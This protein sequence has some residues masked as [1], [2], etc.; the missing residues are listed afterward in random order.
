MYSVNIKKQLI[1][2]WSWKWIQVS[3]IEI[4]KKYL[5]ILLWTVGLQ[6]LTTACF[7]NVCHNLS[8]MELLFSLFAD[9]YTASYWQEGELVVACFASIAV[10]LRHWFGF[11]ILIWFWVTKDYLCTQSRLCDLEP[12]RANCC[13]VE[14]WFAHNF[15]SLMFFLWYNPADSVHAIIGCHHYSSRDW[16]TALTFDCK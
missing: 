16:V 9:V 11:W 1:R 12:N 10:P 4:S 8:V 15:Y 2:F 6:C 13:F 14:L 3:K 7:G 5:G